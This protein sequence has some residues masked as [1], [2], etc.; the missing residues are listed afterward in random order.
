LGSNFRKISSR[1]SRVAVVVAVV[2]VALAA[3]PLSAGSS[4]PSACCLY[5]ARDFH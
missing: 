4:N 1:G 3:T 2:V 5:A